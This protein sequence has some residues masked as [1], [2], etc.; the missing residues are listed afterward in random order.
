MNV[1]LMPAYE[2]VKLTD[3][4]DVLRSLFPDG[5]ANDLN[6]VMFSTSG[7]HGSYLTIEDVAASLGTVEPC[8]LTVLVIQPRVVRMLYGE[9]EITAED[10]PYLLKLR[11]S[12]KRVFAEQ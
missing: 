10:V 9:V 12:S 3:G 6:F 7:T 4:M 1:F 8:K 5:E 11:E 2:V